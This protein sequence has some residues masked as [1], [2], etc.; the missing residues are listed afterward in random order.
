MYRLFLV[1][2]GAQLGAR[3]T[4]GVRSLRPSRGAGTRAQ[5]SN[6]WL[7]NNADEKKGTKDKEPSKS[8]HGPH[9]IRTLGGREPLISGDRFGADARSRWPNFLG[10]LAEIVSTVCVLVSTSS[11]RRRA[12]KRSFPRVRSVIAFSPYGI[13]IVYLKYSQKCVVCKKHPLVCLCDR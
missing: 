11:I 4:R 6:W 3:A 12:Q 8:S 9:A 13:F 10:Y 1:L 7:K 2:N 5:V